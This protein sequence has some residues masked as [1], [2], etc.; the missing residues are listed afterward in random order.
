MAPVTR[1]SR[2]SETLERALGGLADTLVTG[3]LHGARQGRARFRFL[4]E[5]LQ[6]HTDVIVRRSVARICLH[7]ALEVL[8][9]GRVLP[10]AVL[11]QAAR[12]EQLRRLGAL[13][14]LVQRPNAAIEFLQ[15]P[16]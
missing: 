7:R 12:D 15:P 14:R 4:A 16:E 11:T 10:L 5:R 1:R 2:R 8:E 6:V 9:R 3:D 13:E